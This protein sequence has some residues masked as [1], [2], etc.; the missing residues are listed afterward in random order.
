MSDTGYQRYRIDLSTFAAVQCHQDDTDGDIDA[1]QQFQLLVLASHLHVLFYEYQLAEQLFEQCQSLLGVTTSLQGALGKRTKFQQDAHSQ[2]FLTVSRSPVP[3]A[4]AI[5]AALAAAMTTQLPND[6]LVDD[7]VLLDA[8]VFLEAQSVDA[9]GPSLA[10]QSLLVLQ[11]SLHQLTRAKDEVTMEECAA[12]LAAARDG[13]TGSTW[14]VASELLMQRS[15]LA[16]R[17][18]RRTER[19]L[20]QLDELSA[21]FSHRIPP[22]RQRTAWFFLARLPA[23]WELQ[24]RLA[25]AMS[26]MGMTR[27]ALDLLLPWDQWGAIIDCCIALGQRERAERLIRERIAADGETAELLCSLGDVTKDREHYERAWTVS[28][29]RSARAMRSLAQHYMYVDKDHE[30]AA[31][32][33][34][35][36]LAINQ[37]QVLTWFTYG[38]CCMQMGAHRKAVAAYKQCLRL[39]PDVSDA[40][41]GE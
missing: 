6:H 19:S 8:P 40:F 39:E 1:L 27:S 23:L 3:S 17:S 13:R 33:F 12:I 37:L 31:A 2:L 30:R 4:T 16:T 20:M 10:E 32:C 7:E 15:Q 25:R 41:G 35:K 9:G 11:A 38:W 18:S 5:N 22:A 24:L 34:E 14:A 28:R 29:E 21:Q 26:S 36:S